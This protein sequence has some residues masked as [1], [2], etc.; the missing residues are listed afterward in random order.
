MPRFVFIYHG[1][2]TPAS[3]AE[4]RKVMAAWTA[5][6]GTLG[7]AVID[8]GAPFGPSSTVSAGHVAGN[9]GSNPASGY[10]IVE[11]ADMDGAIALAKGCPIVAEPGGSVEIAQ[12]M[13]M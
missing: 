6:F 3:E 2:A 5:W 1:G 4:G 8:A 13:A 10:S 12:A 9:G 7:K 11:A